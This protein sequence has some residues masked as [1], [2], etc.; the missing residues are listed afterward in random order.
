M[1][2]QAVSGHSR[3]ETRQLPPITCGRC[4]KKVRDGTGRRIDRTLLCTKCA[5]KTEAR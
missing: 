5:A 4:G 1:S 3:A 2:G